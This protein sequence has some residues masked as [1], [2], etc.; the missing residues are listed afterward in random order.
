MMDTDQQQLQHNETDPSVHM[1]TDAIEYNFSF[2]INLKVTIVK[3]MTWKG[4]EITETTEVKN[5][6]W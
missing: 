6:Q 2:F 5:P 4:A 1:C 3:V